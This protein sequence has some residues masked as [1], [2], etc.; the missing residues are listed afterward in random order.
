MYYHSYKIRTL[1][2]RLISEVVVKLVCTE[3]GTLVV[4]RAVSYPANFPHYLIYHPS[5]SRLY[6]KRRYSVKM[7]LRSRSIVTLSL[8]VKFRTS[9]KG[10][11]RGQVRRGER[12]ENEQ[13]DTKGERVCALRTSALR[14]FYVSLGSA[15]S[16]LIS[17]RSHL[18]ACRV[19]RSRKSRE[20]EIV[21]AHAGRAVTRASGEKIALVNQAWVERITFINWGKD[22]S[23]NPPLRMEN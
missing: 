6:T 22:I 15:R 10:A 1:W 9:V 11:Q 23:V 18:R 12:R 19:W 20:N 4:Y 14:M 3:F 7:F 13:R 17:I 16:S 8:F 2:L 21:R 5:I